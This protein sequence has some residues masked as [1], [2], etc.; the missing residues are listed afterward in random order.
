MADQGDTDSIRFFNTIAPMDCLQWL[1]DIYHSSHQFGFKSEQPG[2]IMFFISEIM[3]NKSKYSW[4]TLLSKL[5]FGN[6]GELITTKIK[7][8]WT[9][10]HLAVILTIYFY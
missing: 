1:L 5:L 6:K 2:R 8:H 3:E 9:L 7:A 10:P 4:S